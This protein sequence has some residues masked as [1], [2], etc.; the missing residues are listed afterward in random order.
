M[1]RGKHVKLII[2]VDGTCSVDAINFAGPACQVATM[3]IASALGGRIGHEH[4]KPEARIRERSGH[5][6]REEAR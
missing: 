1:P 4:L 2:G 3:E 6:E 5:A